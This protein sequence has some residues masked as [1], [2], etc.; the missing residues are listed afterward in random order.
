MKK[1][2][3]LIT[4]IILVAPTLCRAQEGSAP[5]ECAQAVCTIATP[6]TDV[7]ARDSGWTEP[8]TESIPEK[9]TAGSGN[10]VEN[11]A[12]KIER[13]TDLPSITC[14]ISP[15]PGMAALPCLAVDAVNLASKAVGW[16][17]RHVTGRTEPPHD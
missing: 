6:A 13:A 5:N 12:G 3:I 2:M 16:I 8:E 14:G 1:L 17:A 4:G 7:A 10:T 11:A 15:A 9:P